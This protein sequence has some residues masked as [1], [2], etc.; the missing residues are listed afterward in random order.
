MKAARMEFAVSS[1]TTLDEL[2]L[3]RSKGGF[4]LA[5]PI[6]FTTIDDLPPI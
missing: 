3:Q 6:P 5:N 4:G 1:L 2:A